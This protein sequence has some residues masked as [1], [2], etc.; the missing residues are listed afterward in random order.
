MMKL[1]KISDVPAIPE[2]VLVGKQTMD[3]SAQRYIMGVVNV[4]P[5][6]FSDGGLYSEQ[7]RALSHALSLLKE[8]A[9]IIDIGGESTRPGAKAVSEQEEQDRVLPLIEQLH[10]ARPDC[11]ISIDTTK[12]SVARAACEAGAT[13]INDIS[14]LTFDDQMA[15]VA[16]QTGAALV[17]MHIQGKPRTMQHNPTYEDVVEEVYASLEQ[18]VQCAVNEGVQASQ[19]IIDPGIGFGKTVEH[20]YTLMQHLP[21]FVEMGHAVLLGPSRKSFLGAQLDRSTQPDERIWATAAVV[22]IGIYA[23]AHIVR[24]HDVDQMRDVVRISEAC[25]GILR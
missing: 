8:G 17:V 5:D 24:V 22:A 18:S 19:I 13:M 25:C 14:G 9:H 10:A 21:R 6:S 12:S 23:G 7:D 11:I 3:F 2:G 4:T 15:S 16:A 20:N 1:A